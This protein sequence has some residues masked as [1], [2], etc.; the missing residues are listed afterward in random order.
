MAGQ[1]IFSIEPNKNFSLTNALPRTGV[2]IALSKRHNIFLS[3]N[4][5]SNVCL[6]YLRGDMIML[7]INTRLVNSN[8]L[9]RE[10]IKKYIFLSK[11]K[12]YP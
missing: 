8:T 6:P 4:N 11:N 1:P 10:N 5:N 7:R 3:R 12:N 9:Y 2:H